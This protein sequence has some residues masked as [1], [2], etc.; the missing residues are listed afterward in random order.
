MTTKSDHKK[1]CVPST[2]CK[3]PSDKLYPDD[4]WLHNHISARLF[5]F[6]YQVAIM[7]GAFLLQRATWAT[8]ITCS[9]LVVMAPLATAKH[10]RFPL[11]KRTFARGVLHSLA[12]L[13]MAGCWTRRRR[14]GRWWHRGRRRCRSIDNGNIC[15]ILPHLCGLFTIP[16][17]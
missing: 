10:A 6:R 14:W 4:E 1:S 5:C 15:A 2:R 16:T 12:N 9:G 8:D 11:P 3:S 13:L 17:P 7:K